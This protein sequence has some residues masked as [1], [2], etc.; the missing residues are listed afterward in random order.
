MLPLFSF[1][2]IDVNGSKRLYPTPSVG[3]NLSLGPCRYLSTVRRSSNQGS[4]D[5]SRRERL[6]RLTTF[7]SLSVQ[8]LQKH[9][10]ARSRMESRTIAC[11]LDGIW[12]R[13][14][15]LERIYGRFPS[16]DPSG[17]FPGEQPVERKPFTVQPLKRP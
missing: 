10:E 3:S 2:G 7:D 12:R 15:P 8:V 1:S 13:L 17:R 14:E 4:V 16:M 11:F 6:Q 9:L 5:G